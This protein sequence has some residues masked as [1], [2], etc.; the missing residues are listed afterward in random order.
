M[1]NGKISII[2]A[3]GFRLIYYKPIF[4]DIFWRGQTLDFDLSSFSEC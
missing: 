3:T 2:A 1:K 4:A